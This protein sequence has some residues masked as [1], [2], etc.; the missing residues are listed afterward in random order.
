VL[1][2]IHAEIVVHH[3][4]GNGARHVGNGTGTHLSRS[5]RT[6]LHPHSA[7][8][9]RQAQFVDYGYGYYQGSPDDKLPGVAFFSKRDLAP[10]TSLDSG[11]TFFAVQVL[12]AKTTCVADSFLVDPPPDY[13]TTEP[14]D[15][16]DFARTVA[17]PGDLDGYE[18][19]VGVL[20][21]SPCVAMHVFI[22]YSQRATPK[23]DRARL[24]GM[25]DAIAKTVTVRRR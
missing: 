10:G 3:P 12:P 16:A 20:S 24:L 9:E 19:Q 17:E 13:F 14:E 23:F 15:T 18:E 1:A 25:F 2:S 4:S 6:F 22:T 11:G 8:L 7:G 5:V 21:H